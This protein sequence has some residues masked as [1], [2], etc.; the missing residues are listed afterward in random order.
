MLIHSEKKYKRKKK[1][2]LSKKKKKEPVIKTEQSSI[3][4]FIKYVN[5]NFCTFREY[6]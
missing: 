1:K 4:I 5:C 2:K 3:S 6:F